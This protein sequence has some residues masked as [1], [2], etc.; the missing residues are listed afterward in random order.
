MTSK[1][2][3]LLNQTAV[4]RVVLTAENIGHSPIAAAFIAAAEK[5]VKA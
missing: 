4:V 3:P 1:N 5:T 2:T